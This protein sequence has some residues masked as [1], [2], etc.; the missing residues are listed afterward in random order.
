VIEKYAEG[1]PTNV[2]NHELAS[3][4]SESVKSGDITVAG[5]KEKE[6][7]NIPPVQEKP[8]I[9]HNAYHD[10]RALPVM[11]KEDTNAFVEG[12]KIGEIEAIKK[13]VEETGISAPRPGVV[14]PPLR[15]TIIEKIS[16]NEKELL[17]TSWGKLEKNFIQKR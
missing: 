1:V 3:D 7:V 8:K 14:E 11:H 13:Q 17:N 2:P 12:K 4:S 15:E 9:A 5:Q 10:D 16:A 6:G